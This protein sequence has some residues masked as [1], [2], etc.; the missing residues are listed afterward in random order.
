M[1]TI[2]ILLMAVFTYSYGVYASSAVAAEIEVSAA[3]VKESIPGTENGAGYFTIT[4]V[5]TNK[6][7]LIGAS[8]N[9]ARATEVHQ[10]ILRDGMMRMKRVPE[11]AIAPSE[12][13]VFQ[14]GGYHLMLFGVKK[15]FREGEQVEFT[16]KFSDGYQRT[17]TAEV[18][19]IR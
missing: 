10:H 3:W 15:P 13:L 12:T 19:P 8:T 7:T 17:F 5:G 14:P 18:K 9:S 1:R 6:I 4:N 2:V 11:L 16:L